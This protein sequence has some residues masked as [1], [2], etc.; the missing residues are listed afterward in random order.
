MKLKKRKIWLDENVKLSRS[1]V[2]KKHHE[3]SQR[4]SEKLEKVFATQLTDKR[5]CM[6]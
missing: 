6:P 4:T 1:N 3:Q 5:T 2:F